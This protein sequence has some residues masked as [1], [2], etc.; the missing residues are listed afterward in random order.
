MTKLLKYSGAQL[1]GKIKY[2]LPFNQNPCDNYRLTKKIY[3]LTD[4][5]YRDIK[6]QKKYIFQYMIHKVVF[7]AGI[8][9]FVIRKGD[10]YKGVLLRWKL[11]N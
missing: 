11:L 1:S 2:N 4:K 7:A 9:P 3:S 5:M 10:S 6:R 8:K